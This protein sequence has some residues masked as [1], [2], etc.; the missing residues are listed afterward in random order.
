MGIEIVTNP[1]QINSKE[2]RWLAKVGMV[3]IKVT[4][5]AI[6]TSLEDAWEENGNNRSY[7]AQV[8]D[9]HRDIEEVLKKC[10][11]VKDVRWLGDL[12]EEH[13]EPFAHHNASENDYF[14]QES[15]AFLY[16]HLFIPKSERQYAFD[17]RYA[18]KVIEKAHVIYNGMLFLAFAE[19]TDEVSSILFGQEIR[20]FLKNRLVSKRWEGVIVPPCPLHPDITVMG[21]PNANR[22]QV[23]TNEEND[24]EVLLPLSDWESPVAFLEDFLFD[25]SFSICHFLS[26]CTIEQRMKRTS[27]SIQEILT[28]LT[29]SYAQLLSIPWY[30]IAHKLNLMRASRQMALSLQVACNEFAK[31][32]LMLRKEREAFAPQTAEAWNQNSFRPYFFKNLCE[33]ALSLAE[34]RETVK[35]MTDIVSES[36]LQYSTVFAAIVGGIVGA[37]ITNIPFVFSIISKCFKN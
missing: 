6:V 37:I 11:D 24:V 17:V 32:Q 27:W 28:S 15:S 21:S 9:I 2:S 31:D 26:A 14:L 3:L 13:F 36:Y 8:L 18:D 5:Q 10:P 34:I 33:P 4:D 16:F 20:E 19:T 23:A 29:D 35:H 22:F 12:R 1:I 30:K 25:N 7:Y